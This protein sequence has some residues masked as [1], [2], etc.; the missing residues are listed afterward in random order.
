MGPQFIIIT[1]PL[2][3]PCPLLELSDLGPPAASLGFPWPGFLTFLHSH[4]SNFFLLCLRALRFLA[5]CARH[6]SR[7]SLSLSIAVSFF[8]FLFSRR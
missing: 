2:V 7:Y 8:S 6:V 4:L 3:R 1:L 5:F